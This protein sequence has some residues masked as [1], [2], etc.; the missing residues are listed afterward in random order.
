MVYESRTFNY[1][2][3][4]YKSGTALRKNKS[5][6]ISEDADSEA[7]LG[8]KTGVSQNKKEPP[9]STTQS[10]SG[11]SVVP[12]YKTGRGVRCI[13]G[14]TPVIVGKTTSGDTKHGDATT[15]K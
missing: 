1:V 7:G 13:K 6:G 15:R 5:G 9:G 11:V 10:N 3:L 2:T 12:N 8:I 14:S 4:C